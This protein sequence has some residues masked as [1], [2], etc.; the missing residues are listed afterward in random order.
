MRAHIH[1][2]PPAAGRGRHGALCAAALCAALIGCSSDDDRSTSFSYIYA[3]IIEPSCTTIGCHNEFVATYDLELDTLEEAYE[4]LV[5][6]PCDPA[7]PPDPA[8]ATYVIPGQPDRSKL[9]YLMEGDDV[10]RR[11]PPDTPLPAAD[12]DLVRQWILEGAECSR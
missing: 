1:L 7:T 5:G 8:A 9:I 3:T 2:S 12:I 4:D 6:S 10:P 11:M